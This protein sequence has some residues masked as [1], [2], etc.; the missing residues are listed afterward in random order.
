MHPWQ[1][2][3]RSWWIPQVTRYEA[4]EVSYIENMLKG[5]SK[6]R[7]V[8]PGFSLGDWGPV[9]VQQGNDPGNRDGA[10]VVTVE[11]YCY[12][13]SCAFIDGTLAIDATDSAKLRKL[14]VPPPELSLDRYAAFEKYINLDRAKIL[15]ALAQALMNVFLEPLPKECEAI[16]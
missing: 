12:A 11:T 8:N 2:L 1:T 15:R 4:G 10:P 9:D 14:P 7:D 6:K 13:E 5:E 16:Q 3:M